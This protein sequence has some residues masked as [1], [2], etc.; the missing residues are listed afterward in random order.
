MDTRLLI[1]IEI[2]GT[3][4]QAVLGE[5]CGRIHQ[6]IQVRADAKSGAVRILEQVREMVEHLLSALSSPVDCIGVGFGGPVD[7]SMGI[8]IKSNQVTGWEDMPLSD[9]VEKQFGVPSIISNDT[10]AATVAEARHPSRHND[11]FVFYSNV[12]SGI[13]GGLAID[14]KLYQR[15]AGAMEIGH[16][17]VYSRMEQSH[18]TLE[19]Y[20]S[21]WSLDRRAKQAAQQYTD[22]LLWE[23]GNRGIQHIGASELFDAWQRN[24]VAACE[25]VE[26][27]LECYASALT[28]AIMLLNPDVVVVGGGLSKV[29]DPLLEALQAKIEQMIYPPWI[30]QF[31]IELTALGDNAV[32]TGAV[33]LAA[34]RFACN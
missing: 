29:G 5:P 28:T 13:G 26:D 4:L 23:I 31:R 20:C 16:T 8:V 12:G 19:E 30:D 7:D 3:K 14:G 21:G 1:G 10:D 22:S 32:P 25:V 18:G 2:G 33:L 34:D 17:R 27:F 11:R 15:P 6:T 9:W 24:D